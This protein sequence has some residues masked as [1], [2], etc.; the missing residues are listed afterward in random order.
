MTIYDCAACGALFHLQDELAV[1]AYEN[2][3][4][5]YRPFQWLS[6]KTALLGK[7]VAGFLLRHRHRPSDVFCDVG[8][9]A[10]HVLRT[11]RAFGYRVIGFDL[12]SPATVAM[13]AAGLDIVTDPA[14]LLSGWRGRCARLTCW[15]TLE[16]VP[17]AQAFLDMLVELLAPEGVLSIEVP[18]ADLTR[19]L[20][21][22][23]GPESFHRIAK[24]PEHLA[25]CSR[26][27][28]VDQ[29]QRRGLRIEKVFDPADGALYALGNR[30][31]AFRTKP[32]TARP[33]SPSRSPA[34]TEEEHGSHGS[35]VWAL[36]GIAAF[37]LEPL[38][39]LLAPRTAVHIRAMKTQ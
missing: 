6:P 32:A 11:A 34:C 26:R 1:A 7:K 9:G 31:G 19:G 15:H 33:I 38:A 10:G 21:R 18:E 28:L 17:D 25:L 13:R 4:H 30:F 2:D 14:A 36:T 22:G 29:L 3:Y 37:L 12:P 39:P 16:H 20:C 24:M 8:C 23:Y 5:A 27:W 35:L